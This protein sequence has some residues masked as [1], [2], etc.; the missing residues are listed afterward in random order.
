MMIRFGSARMF[1]C[2]MFSPLLLGWLIVPVL[3]LVQ[4]LRF[5]RRHAGGL[6]TFLVILLLIRPFFFE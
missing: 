3:L 2:V 1:P 6:I 4:F 5:L